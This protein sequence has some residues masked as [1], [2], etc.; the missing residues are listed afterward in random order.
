M[1]NELIEEILSA[2]LEARE[3]LR[4]D[5]KTYIKVFHYYLYKQEFIFK[6]FHLL[7][8]GKLENFV[9]NHNETK[10]LLIN[11]S[12]RTGK[13]Q[14][15][16][17]FISWML[18]V[19]KNKEFIYTSY[20][21]LL[22]RKFSSEI[23][24]LIDTSLYNKLFNINLKQDTQAKNLWKIEDG[25][26]FLASSLKSGITGWGS[27]Y[28]IIDDPLNSTD[29]KSTVE[30]NN[31]I[32][33]FNN[34]LKS[35]FND[36]TQ[37]RFILIMQR[38][39]VDDLTGYIL[40]N[41]KEAWDVV[42]IPAI[43]ENNESI[44]PEKLPLSFLEKERKANN[45]SFQAQYMQQPINQGGNLI[46]TE[47]FKR[48]LQVPSG[49]DSLYITC[50]TATST[51]TSADYSAF[52]LFGLIGKNIYLIDLYN[53]KVVYPDLKRDLKAFYQGYV[54]FYKKPITVYIEAKSSGQCLIPDLRETGLP[55]SELAPTYW[56]AEK[57]KE[58]TGDKLTRFYEV[59][60]DL[61]S[62]YFHIPE[63]ASWLYDFIN[64]CESFTGLGDVHDDIVDVTI[65]GLKVRRTRQN[66]DWNNFKKVFR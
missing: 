36:K 45:F 34:S 46:K 48:Y 8:I 29:Y 5:L 61:E 64:Q 47:W 13:S 54:D 16:K 51:K 40:E 66:I 30:K 18:C 57:K 25:G 9:F 55:I 20:S 33:I 11:I 17:Y 15:I 31:V 1:N 10:H 19:D 56:S 3:L 26:Q 39:A 37:G 12:P 7:L 43:N 2:P 59:S 52:G 27:D 32:D 23:R 41:E 38:L 21:D 65:Y 35:R 44:F 50:D 22:I 42:S 63:S 58:I 53:K 62:G 4:S 49:F 14:L 60:C 6:N 28:T 24:D